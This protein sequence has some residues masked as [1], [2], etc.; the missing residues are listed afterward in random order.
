MLHCHCHVI[1]YLKHPNKSFFNPINIFEIFYHT[2][3]LFYNLLFSFNVNI[4]IFT[5]IEEETKRIEI[6]KEYLLQQAFEN[7]ELFNAKAVALAETSAMLRQQAEAEWETVTDEETGKTYYVS[8]TTG[9]SQW[10][11]KYNSE[12]KSMHRVMNVVFR[13]LQLLLQKFCFGPI[14]TYLLL[15]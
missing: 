12:W 11:N 1:L 13:F 5:A 10:V 14:V 4:Y 15:F 2:L 9:Q 8:K 6:E 7:A 3:L